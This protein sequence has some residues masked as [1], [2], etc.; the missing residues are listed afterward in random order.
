M[1]MEECQPCQEIDSERYDLYFEQLEQEMIK[2]VKEIDL[3]KD[4]VR[5]ER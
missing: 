2:K 5:K 1:I 4:S 3:L